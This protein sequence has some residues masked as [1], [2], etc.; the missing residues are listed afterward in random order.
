MI[1]SIV[2]QHAPRRARVTHAHIG[3]S[4]LSFLFSNDRHIPYVCVCACMREAARI[5]AMRLTITGVYHATP[6]MHNADVCSACTMQMNVVH[7][8]S[9]V[10]IVHACSAHTHSACMM[11]THT[12]HA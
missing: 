6:G 4:F 3:G 5:G 10:H 11:H 1:V 2:A 7:A 9:Y 12:V 8:P